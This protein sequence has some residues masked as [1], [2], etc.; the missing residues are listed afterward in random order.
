M[1]EEAVVPGQQAQSP[2]RNLVTEEVTEGLVQ[3][4]KGFAMAW[5]RVRVRGALEVQLVLAQA[6]TAG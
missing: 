2:A 3:P 5:D 1:L 4:E 6:L